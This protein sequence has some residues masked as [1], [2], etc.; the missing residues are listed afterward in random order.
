MIKNAS[1]KYQF[2]MIKKKSQGFVTE[3]IPT[4][5]NKQSSQQANKIISGK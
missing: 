2:D 3:L 1:R 4:K 5:Q